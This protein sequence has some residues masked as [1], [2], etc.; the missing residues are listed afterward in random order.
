M[1]NEFNNLT[2]TTPN[3]TH[4]ITLQACVIGGTLASLVNDY[5]HQVD[6]LSVY[7]AEAHPEGVWDLGSLTSYTK[8]H[9][10][11]QDRMD[12]AR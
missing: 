9:K 11:L 5:R 10:S 8:Q 4:F 1:N 12:A 3:S 7:L 2:L 6:F